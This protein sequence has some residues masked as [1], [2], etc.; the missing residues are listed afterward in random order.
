V[1]ASI[2]QI[3]SFKVFMSEVSEQMPSMELPIS[4]EVS[5]D[6]SAQSLESLPPSEVLDQS[7]QVNAD[8]N[9]S[10]QDSV[11]IQPEQ[12]PEQDTET[13]IQEKE[14]MD[15]MLIKEQFKW[16]GSMIRT[17]KKRKDATIFLQPVDPIALGIPTYFTVIT[18][19]M[20]VSTIEK[21]MAAHEYKSV[22]GIFSDF[23]LMF[24]NCYTFNGAE[25][26]IGLICK[27]L[28]EWY[29]KEILKLPRSLKQLE[30]KKRKKSMSYGL[31]P[32]RTTEQPRRKSLGRKSNPEMKF[33][34]YVHRELTKKQNQ[35]F[36]WPF[37]TPV[38]PEGMGIPHYRDVIKHP[39]D[40]STIRKK[41]D[42]VEYNSPGEFEA[43]VR[44]MLN[45]CFTFNPAGTDVYVCGKQLEA[46]FEMKWNEMTSF[47]SQYGERLGG[48]STDDDDD[49]SI[50]SLP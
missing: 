39:M 48:D 18:H 22:D 21:K 46:L 10:V 41:L 30:S 12:H 2:V 28:H 25:S 11:Q 20:D 34:N 50:S 1:A 16:V 29:S 45:N 42:L 49:D 36:S 31:E 15:P 14:E 19:P 7:Q 5:H 27:S 40:L 6:V 24:Q 44:L 47:L 37:M 3:L 9:E 38:D 35:A 13:L 43:D 8:Q 17:M 33:C 23:E 4:T 32:I 26:A